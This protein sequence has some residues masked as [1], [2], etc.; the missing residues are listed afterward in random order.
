MKKEEKLHRVKVKKYVHECNISNSGL[1]HFK[2]DLVED[3]H[4]GLTFNTQ[5]SFMEKRI[6]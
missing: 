4:G 2:L 5:E 1:L 6:R 3:Q